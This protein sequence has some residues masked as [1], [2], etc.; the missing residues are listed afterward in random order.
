MKFYDLKG[1]K[2]VEV[3]E[4]NVVKTKAE[5]KTKTGKQV[6]YQLIASYDGRK[7]YKFVGEADFKAAKCKEV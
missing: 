7:L 2:H 5:R 3:D 1:K 4:A 6:R